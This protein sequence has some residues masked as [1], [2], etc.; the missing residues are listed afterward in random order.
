MTI[1][2]IT[3][4]VRHER[5]VRLEFSASLAAGAFT[6]LTWYTFTS[7]GTAANPSAVAAYA[8]PNSPQTVELHLSVPLVQGALYTVS[9]VGV[10]AVGGGST[11]DPSTARFRVAA[12]RGNND[13]GAPRQASDLEKSL[14]GSDLVHDGNDFVEGPDGDLV[15]IAG[16]PVVKGDLRRGVES[17]G[18]PWAPRHGLRA[19]EAFVDAPA[20][21][22]DQIPALAVAYVQRDDRVVSATAE[23]GGTSERPIVRIKP[24]LIGDKLVSG[25]GEIQAAIR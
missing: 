8:V 22:L 21:M 6:N 15:R 17:N 10:P 24:V 4:L 20:P 12:E 14:Y 16:L 13:L 25:A 3:A 19:R 23:V 11:P 18:L 1:A 2:L 5:R 7:D 9:A